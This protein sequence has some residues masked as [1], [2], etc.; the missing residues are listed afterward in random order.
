MAS[1][2]RL[3]TTRN[4]S[5]RVLNSTLKTVKGPRK[6]EWASHRPNACLFSFY[7]GRKSPIK[8]LCLKYKLSIKIFT[9]RFLKDFEKASCVWSQIS[10]RMSHCDNVP[11]DTVISGNKFLTKKKSLGPHPRHSPYLSIRVFL[12]FPSRRNILGY[13]R[14]F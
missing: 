4:P 6:Q 7:L 5:A 2:E 8:I 3:S 11:S 9:N 1:F 10:I 13:L 14:M 12:L